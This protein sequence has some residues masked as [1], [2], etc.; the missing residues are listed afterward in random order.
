M[1]YLVRVLAVSGMLAVGGG[2][3]I[4]TSS[5]ASM[6]NVTGEAW[7]SEAIGFAGLTW[8]SKVWYCPA[9]TAAGPSTCKEAKMIA[10]TKEELDAQKEAEKNAAAK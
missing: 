9:P 6:T 8:G 4:V 10:L 7:Y 1:R 2:C 3:A 5:G